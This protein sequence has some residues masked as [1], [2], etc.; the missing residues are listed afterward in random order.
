MM[1]GELYATSAARRWGQDT[2]F[3]SLSGWGNGSSVWSAWQASTQREVVKLPPTTESA[4][5]RFTRGARIASNLNHPNITVVHDYGRTVLGDLYL[6]MEL[7]DGMNLFRASRKERLTVPRIVHMMDQ[8][9]RAL[10]HAH[11]RSVV[12]RDIKLSNLFLTPTEDDPDFVKV[13][14][15]GIARQFVLVVPGPIRMP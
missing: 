9:L 4:T 1:A 5:E 6:V 15:F 8:V 10:G 12:H 13:L 2:H 14:D 11:R 3:G 7:M